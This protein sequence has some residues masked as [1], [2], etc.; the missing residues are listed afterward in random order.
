MDDT[1]Y[2]I[3]YQKSGT[4]LNMYLNGEFMKFV[5]DESESMCGTES[6]APLMIG[7]RQTNGWRAF[8][9][10]VDEL[11]IYSRTLTEEEIG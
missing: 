10:V 11:R 5:S 7:A 2:H 3:V 6:D 9:G 1:F 4:R 8:E